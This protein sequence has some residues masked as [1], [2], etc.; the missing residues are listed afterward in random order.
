MRPLE[1][2]IKLSLLW[3]NMDLKEQASLKILWS[4]TEET[5]EL[6]LTFKTADEVTTLGD[7]TIEGAKFLA[8]NDSLKQIASEL[9]KNRSDLAT[10]RTLFSKQDAKSTI[11]FDV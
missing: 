4:F 9:F 1:L 7:I 3:G 10:E 2:Q 6:V 11:E 8:L 5:D